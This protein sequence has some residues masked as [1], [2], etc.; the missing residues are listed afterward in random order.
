MHLLIVSHSCA[1]ATNQQI[2]AEMRRQTGWKLTIV[3]PAGWKDEFGN[4]LDEAPWP[5][6]EAAVRKV[7]VW[8]NG[9]IV[10]HGY[11]L[12]WRRFLAETRPDAI[13]VNHEPYAVATGQVVAAN[14]ATLRRPVGFYS[15]QNLAKRYPFPFSV[16]E[17]MVYQECRFAFPITEAVSAVLAAKG[18]AGERVVCPLALDPERY[19]PALRAGTPP[20]LERGAGEP[21]IGFVGRLVE[22]KGLRTLAVALADLTDVPWRLVLVGRGSFEE[23]FRE[24][25]R[26]GG[27]LERVQFAGYVPHAETPRWLAALDVLVLPS[28]TQANWTEQFGRVIP[29]ALACGVPVVGSDSGEIPNL[30]RTS[31]G[32][33][34]FPER[35][36]GALAGALRG[37]LADAEGRKRCAEAGREWVRREVAL[38]AVAARMAETVGRIAG[39]DGRGEG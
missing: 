1:T 33:V 12:D 9:R 21:R 8:A 7:P 25:A 22:S 38:P 34:V 35:N 19:H 11:R 37:F 2:Y 20:E 5:G 24:L 14:R 3:A 10:L 15:C 30:I 17:R 13:Y 18:F 29:E 27:F 4:V 23:R 16:I 39:K 31:G 32:G 6:L 26:E 36:A 28:E